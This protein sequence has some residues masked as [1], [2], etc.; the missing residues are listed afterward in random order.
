MQPRNPAP[1]AV[2]DS[3]P[4]RVARAG[5]RRLFHPTLSD[6]EEAVDRAAAEARRF[7]WK[8]VEG[9]QEFIGTRVR[10]ELSVDIGVEY[11]AD[12]TQTQA[13][14]LKIFTRR[15]GPVYITTAMEMVRAAPAVSA[16]AKG[17]Q[18]AAIPA[19]RATPARR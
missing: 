15:A 5:W 10:A 1:P 8:S 6:L 13:R 7:N 14:L 12:E 19:I 16:A 3:L 18:A 11:E 9:L 17:G 2:A 4:V